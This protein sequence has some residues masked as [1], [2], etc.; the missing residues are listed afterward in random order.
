M[1]TTPWFRGRTWQ[2]PRVFALPVGHRVGEFLSLA[3]RERE[4]DLTAQAAGIVPAST[5]LLISW[6]LLSWRKPLVG[7]KTQFM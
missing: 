1:V 2:G 4:L 3:E 5:C 6:Y 7:F